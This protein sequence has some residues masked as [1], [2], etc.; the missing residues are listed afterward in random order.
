[1]ELKVIDRKNRVIEVKP[2]SDE[3][4]WALSVT[5]RPGDYVTAR[6]LRDVAV[7]GSTKERRPVTV[8]LKVKYTEFQPF[9]G[10]LRIYGVIVEGPD[11]YG[12]KGKHHAIL[13]APGQKIV[14]EREEGWSR[15]DLKRLS[16]SSARGRAVVAAVD[17]DE[18]AIAV[19]AHHGYKLSFEGYS[20]LPGKDD[21]RREQETDRYMSE[22]ASAIVEAAAREGARIVVVAGPG[23]LKNRIADKVR[24]AAPT[25]SVHVD[26]VSIGGRP[27][28][29]E[30]IRRPTLARV[31]REYSLV[32]AEEWFSEFMRR[33]ARS[34]GR[35]AYTLEAVLKAAELGALE[36]LVM[37]D[38]LLYSMDD[39]VREAADRILRAAERVRA[40]ALLVPRDS[41]V[42]ERIW[43]MGGV[44][45][46]LRFEIST[47]DYR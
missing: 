35:V 23:D 38:E 8:K 27:G 36:R 40:E 19:V 47:G 20:R 16:A 44:I 45:A 41:P 3:D 15:A 21:P 14:L 28:V 4:L 46:L 5:L 6:T 30:A 32:K 34:P 37:V 39:R 18:Y 31:L 33:V 26:S 25:L 29:E 7:K 9:T 10:K 12:L 17:Y 42:G 24:S 1:M 2:E 22:I 43:R 11:E 13:L